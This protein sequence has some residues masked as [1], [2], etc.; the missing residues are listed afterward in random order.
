MRNGE[1]NLYGFKKNY[2]KIGQ[3]FLII[4]LLGYVLSG[5]DFAYLSKNKRKSRQ[6]KES[7]AIKL[8]RSTL[9]AMGGESKLRQ[10]S[11]V[12]IEGIGHTY[13]VEQS[14]RPTGPFIVAYQQIK[15]LRD[16]KAL[17]LRQTIETRRVQNNQWT[18][19]TS[20]VSDNVAAVESGGKTFPGS[21][22]QV[23]ITNQRIALAPE[24]IFF[25][26]L[27]A[28]DLRLDKDTVMQSVPQHVV[29]FTWQNIPVTVYLN[30]YTNLPTAVETLSASPYEHFWSVWGDFTTRVFY[31]YWSLMPG[32]I[33]Y[34]YQWDTERN[35]YPLESFAVTNLKFNDD[36][37]SDNFAISDDIR[38][39]FQARPVV[40]IDDLPLGRTDRPIVELADGIVEIPGRW[41]S[42]IVRQKDGIV[43]MESPISSGYSIKVMDEAKRRF[44]GV[45]IKA[46][47]TTADAFPHFGGIREYAAEGIPIYALD[48]NVPLLER[49]ISAPFKFYP[50]EL[51]RKPRKPNFKLVSKKTIVG[52]GVNR[53]ELYPI[54]TE[55]G[56]RMMM[57]YFPEHKLLY[58]SDM[59]QRRQDGTFF[60]PQYLSEVIQAVNRENLPVENIIAMHTGKTA[61][62]EI[63][64]V[65]EKLTS[66]ASH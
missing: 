34:P 17:C 54:K 3:V 25:T 16:L 20:I 52:E 53:M 38:Q 49:M 1:D 2:T 14:E 65:V 44:P 66:D 48:L 36:L 10:L 40:K 32:G 27:E 43:I 50:D 7:A 55:T 39:Q 56:E 9:E 28:K 59:V 47:I 58:A 13:Y 12:S 46:V 33:H 22:V 60:M 23:Q 45:P 57:I 37:K 62:A 29:K 21:I 5:S 24:R 26:A 11:N 8:V 19:S 61:Y 64:S 18:A 51:E 30:A 31:T 35:G 4:F 15:E 42:T 41:Y 6:V 63:K